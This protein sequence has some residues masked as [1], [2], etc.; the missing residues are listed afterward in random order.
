MVRKR[1]LT[2]LVLWAA[3]CVGHFCF[4]RWASLHL[5][6]PLVLDGPRW[7]AYV[8]VYVFYFPVDVLSPLGIRVPA[9]SAGWIVISVVWIVTVA[10]CVEGARWLWSIRPGRRGPAGPQSVAVEAGPVRRPAP[11]SSCPPVDRAV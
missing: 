10:A 6:P 3:A 4:T 2:R 11:E 8:V 5:I 9:S 1:I 7:L